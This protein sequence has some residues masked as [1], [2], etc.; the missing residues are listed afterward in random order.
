MTLSLAEVL[1]VLSDLMLGMPWPAVVVHALTML[2]L[3]AGLSGLSVGI[4]AWLPNFRET[5]PSKI[6]VGFGG[7]LNLVVGLVF[8]MTTILLMV[9]PWHMFAVAN[10]GNLDGVSYGL[11]VVGL[12]AGLALGATAVV[13]ALH[14]GV[15]TLRTIEF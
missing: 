10:Q 6:A 4:G 8:L 7:T 1:V 13:V 5:D 14:I 15:R 2:V 3:S 12:L 9:G 11:V